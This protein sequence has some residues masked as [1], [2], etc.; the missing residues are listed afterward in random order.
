VSVVF[1]AQALLTLYLGEKGAERVEDLLNRVL[2]GEIT[3]LVNAVNLAELYYILAR[4]SS[5][6]AEEKERNLR[7]YG[8]KVIPVQDD[9]L[10][11]N[12]A[13]LKARHTL[14]LADAFALATAKK[15]RAVLVTG[16]DPD[17][18]GLKGF[19]IER[20]G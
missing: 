12:A 6:V 4:K 15:H 5:K 20:V 11:K 7:G 17:F 9:D 10:W 16:Q 18:K 8:V 19:M 13:L 2:E 1:D 14:S 3:G